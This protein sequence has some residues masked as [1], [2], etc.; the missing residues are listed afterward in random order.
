MG[1][2][3]NDQDLGKQT[4]PQVLLVSLR[5][6]TKPASP[7]LPKNPE[8]PGLLNRSHYMDPN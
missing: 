1:G 6:S 4:C 5:A 3:E 2:S 7:K 8:Y